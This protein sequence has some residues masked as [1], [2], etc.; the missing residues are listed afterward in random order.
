MRWPALHTRKTVWIFERLRILHVERF[1]RLQSVRPTPVHHS[2]LEKWTQN[3]AS[4]GPTIDGRRDGINHH[5]P[6][7]AEKATLGR[8]SVELHHPVH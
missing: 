4:S 8:I 1:N 2:F 5:I 3:E 6:S 7:V